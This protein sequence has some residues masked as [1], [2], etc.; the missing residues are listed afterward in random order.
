MN[1]Y[2]KGVITLMVSILVI[3]IPSFGNAKT[4]NYIEKNGL[5]VIEAEDFSHQA[6]DKIRRWYLF[7][8]QTPPHNMMDADEMHVQGASGK[9]YIELLP[10]N[11][12]NHDHPLIEGENFTNTPGEM[13]ILS[14][15]VYFNNPGTY[16]IWARAF[17]TG[18]ED[19]G[20]HFGL[21]GQW[22]ES[23]SRLQFCEGKYEWT[24]SSAQRRPS[25]HCGEQHTLEIMVD[26]PGIHTLHL[27]MR[28]DGVELDK[29]ILSK[30]KTFVPSGY[31]PQ[32]TLSVQDKAPSK[33]EYLYVQNFNYIM[34]PNT[35]FTF[36]D[37]AYFDEDRSAFAIR[38]DIKA[39]REKLVPASL[40]WKPQRDGI[41][42]LT[43]VT[44]GEIDGESSY[45][46]LHNGKLIGEFTNP[47]TSIDYDENFFTM[48]D[49]N[50]KEGDI[51][52]VESTAVTNGKIPE[53]DATAFSRGRWQALIFN[54]VKN[55]HAV[56]ANKP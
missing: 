4:L 23:S 56:K 52:V 24:W 35:D 38:A 25:N 49:V 37:P 6:K 22:P 21:D 29:I 36:S 7:D 47:E 17:S 20:V 3:A 50:A 44:L 5:L 18:K 8:A 10:D 48:N 27:S 54:N 39:A 32:R 12:V 11:R 51:F 2:I 45:R 13:A 9:A 34:Q 30:D 14:Y 55:G 26:K 53:G 46:I 16:T 43:L 40:L 42:N 19:N 1:P 33:T 15:P 41:Y 28:E 31:G